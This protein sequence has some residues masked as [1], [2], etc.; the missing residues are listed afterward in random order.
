MS[1]VAVSGLQ[2]SQHWQLDT[3]LSRLVFFLLYGAIILNISST[4]PFL[5]KEIAFTAITVEIKIKHN[6][7]VNTASSV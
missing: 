3:H 4:T 2:R 6:L 5:P 7:E 1:N